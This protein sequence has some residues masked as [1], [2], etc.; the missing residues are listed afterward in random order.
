VK[1][2]VLD[3]NYPSDSNL[4]GDVFVHARVK[5]YIARGHEVHVLAF[6]T[7]GESYSFEGVRVTCVSNLEELNGTIRDIAPE[8]IAIHFFQG[9]MLK[10]LVE[11]TSVPIV[12]WVHGG[13]ALG[14]Y[15]RLFNLRI[16]AEFARYVAFNVLQLARM[17]R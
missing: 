5:G 14:W 16:D 4:Y 17:R 3:I 11:Q 10:K 8:V 13:E 6:F 9:W 15:R 7:R 1:I 2:L 12:V